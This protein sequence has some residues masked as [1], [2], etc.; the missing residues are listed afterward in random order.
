MRNILILFIITLVGST[1]AAQN[2]LPANPDPNK[3]YVRC[4]TPDV[5]ETEEVRVKTHCSYKVLTVVPARYEDRT[6]SVLVHEGYTRYEIIPAEFANEQVTYESEQAY[7]K[8][9]ITEATF[10]DDSEEI[11]I[12]PKTARWE[13]TPY[14]G[15][16]SDNPLD[17]QVLCY[18][19]YPE[20][21]RSI[22]TKT[23]AADATYTAKPEGGAED[24]YT[25]RK[26]TKSAEV[27]EI[28][29][30][31]VYATIE[32]RVLVQDETV[33]EEI[34][35]EKFTTVTREVLKSKGGLEQWEEIECEL[36]EYNVLPINYEYG[37]AR[38]TAEARR[39]ID[40]KLVTL[41]REK[42]GIGIE[43]TAHTDSR[44]SASANQ[45]LSERRAQSVVR[46][47]QSKGFAANRLVA[48]GKGESQLKNRCADGVECS[49]Q[50]HA[51]NRRTEF[52]VLNN[53]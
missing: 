6:D 27:R 15:C 18:R 32:K 17:C 46:Y 12:F 47:L 24:T 52:R 35:P 49:E 44:G 39:I 21:T 31:P 13:Y 50:E 29:V 33:T 38:L 22:P 11:V 2:G 40:E 4:I 43:I 9:T 51:V 10:N 16:E 28:T 41:L 53:M 23:L 34:V 5:Y 20:Q 19:E 14:E 45:L 25:V 37:S 30:E 48:S 26:V 7:N 3:C 36:L 1:V 8:I 42:P